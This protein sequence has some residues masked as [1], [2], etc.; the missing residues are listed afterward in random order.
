M[1]STYVWK[2]NCCGR[3]MRREF[4]QRIGGSVTE[5]DGY[6]ETLATISGRVA[7]Q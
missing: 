2:L 5:E 6:I 1:Q 4:E 7:K 3:R